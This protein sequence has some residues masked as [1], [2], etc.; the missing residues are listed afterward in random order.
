MDLAAVLLLELPR[1]DIG[2]LLVDARL[3]VGGCGPSST[4]RV[5]FGALGGLGAM[6]VLLNDQ[7]M[8]VLECSRVCTVI[9]MKR[10]TRRPTLR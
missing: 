7:I 5:P 9:C 1:K 8:M 2:L 3:G 6:F 4:G 10:R